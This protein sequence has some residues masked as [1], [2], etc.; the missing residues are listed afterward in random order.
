MNFGGCSSSCYKQEFSMCSFHR[1]N[2]LLQSG[3]PYT[4]F[5][6]QMPHKSMVETRNFINQQEI[7]SECLKSSQRFKRFVFMC[8]K[9]N[10]VNFKDIIRLQIFLS[11]W[12]R[13]KLNTKI[14]LTHHHPPHKLLGN[15]ISAVTDLIL[16][17]L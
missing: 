3:S 10:F 6:H 11:A 14:G 1:K 7:D 16:A 5:C 4:H 9:F 12:L 8:N 2:I 17:K 15:N 13:L